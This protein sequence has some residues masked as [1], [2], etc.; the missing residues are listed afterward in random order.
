MQQNLP[1][2]ASLKTTSRTWFY[3]FFSLPDLMKTKQE[4][5]GRKEGGEIEVNCLMETLSLN[6]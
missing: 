3:Y 4:E 1:A 5:V 6:I 2:A